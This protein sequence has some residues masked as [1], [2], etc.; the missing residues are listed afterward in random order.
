MGFK[1]QESNSHRDGKQ[2]FTEAS[3]SV[4]HRKDFDPRCL[5][6][7]SLSHISSY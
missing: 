7:F 5:V 2:M 6:G 4:G 3:L 1:G